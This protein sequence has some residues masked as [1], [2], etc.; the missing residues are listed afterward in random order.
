MEVSNKTG[1]RKVSF[2]FV[3]AIV[4]PFLLI[5]FS[6]DSFEKIQ[7]ERKARQVTLQL[8]SLL[9][10]LADI[11]DDQVFFHVWLQ[12]K[13]Q[14]ADLDNG[15]GH[16]VEQVKRSFGR[17]A[18]I[19]IWNQKGDLIEKLS[20]EKSFQYILKKMFK[21]MSEIDNSI[22][23]SFIVFPRSLNAVRSN[24][25]LLRKYFGSMLYG[26]I[27]DQP[28]YPGI[29]GRAIK[30]S[31]DPE[32]GY[33]WYQKGKS[34]SAAI[35]LHSRLKN[36]NIGLKSVI[37]NFNRQNQQ[38]KVGFFR[39]PET[40]Y[41]GPNLAKSQEVAIKLQS[42]NFTRG[43]FKLQTG[44][45]FSSL[46]RQLSFDVQIFALHF[47]EEYG[48]AS[49]QLFF[50]LLKYLIILCFILYCFSLRAEALFLSVKTRIL[51]LMLFAAVLP[52]VAFG[53][54]G[55]EFFQHKINSLISQQQIEGQRIIK[56]FDSLYPLEKKRIAEEFNLLIEQNNRK[57]GNSRWPDAALEHLKK[58]I[59]KYDPT[60]FGFFKPGKGSEFIGGQNA[61]ELK[62]NPLYS[63][64]FSSILADLNNTKVLKRIYSQNAMEGFVDDLEWLVNS[65]NECGQINLDNILNES[66]IVYQNFVGYPEISDSN[67]IVVITWVVEAFQNM[68]FSNQFENVNRMI[69]PGRLVVMFKNSGRIFS[70]DK[71]LPELIKHF[72]R[73][74]LFNKFAFSDSLQV[75]NKKFV[76][77]GMQGLNL[78]SVAIMYL[79][80]RD[81][82]E[83]K[84]KNLRNGI[85][86]SVLMFLFT[87]TLVIWKF[88]R[89]QLEPVGLLEK[90]FEAV[91]RRDFNCRLDFCSTDEFDDLIRTFNLSLE[92]MKDMEIARSV[93]ESLL[94]PSEFSCGNL[95]VFV[96]TSFMT[97]MGGDY[98]DIATSK[99]KVF[100]A[101]GDV[102][103]HGVPAALVMAMIKAIFTNCLEESD[104]E[105]FLEKCNRVM[106]YLR[107]KGWNL[108]MTLQ[109]LVIEPFTG[110]FSIVNAGHC[111]PVH[112]HAAEP[113][114][115]YVKACGVPLGY[116]FSKNYA[117]LKGALSSDE[118]L[119]LYSDGII[120]ATN[121]NGEPYGFER[122]EG[123]LKNFSGGNLETF[124][125]MIINSV[126]GWS[127]VQADD[128]S[129]M[130]IRLK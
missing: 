79:Y 45:D 59:E 18:K 103:G 5:L 119:I 32:K 125:N 38:F 50:Y 68:F 23:S 93:Q 25:A 92:N 30:I 95:E 14:K 2:Y 113:G 28:L 6:L 51:G 86:A 101:F 55:Y 11:S 17:D 97:S 71:N 46:F 122:F 107:N 82:I 130:V 108:M 26:Q 47:P 102:A 96:K 63:G 61:E 13:F 90:G 8:E 29:S 49:A 69:Y 94:P 129:V 105:K 34:F 7:L 52:C 10:R 89:K 33:F 22:K 84:V 43:V 87:V 65:L 39:L 53:L 112:L 72:L 85:V 109:F 12:R 111:Y 73:Q 41:F 1:P 20:D 60:M 98:F 114:L 24:M 100:V 4:L 54:I 15:A 126:N 99:D 124:C 120:E 127:R 58:H 57:Y 19:I 121:D 128:L 70:E 88:A 62:L 104:E 21:A 118:Y 56:E 78:E 116:R 66:H 77:T 74:A 91:A 76:A 80:P 31:H 37:A 42:M 44:I 36:R 115:S 48:S 16:F 123:M 64:F 40:K 67:G 117:V 3:F 81:L 110:K 106:L 75:D 35:F 83:A 27:M 9:D